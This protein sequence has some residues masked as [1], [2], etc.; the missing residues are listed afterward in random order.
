MPVRHQRKRSRGWRLPP[1][2]VIVTRGTKWGNPFR[3]GHEALP[4][5]GSGDGCRAAGH[6]IRVR[7]A[8]HAVELFR[9]HVRGRED[10]IKADLRGKDLICWCPHGQHCHADVLLEIANE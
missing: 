8:A 6:P 9:A 2:A 5:I 4:I 7:N 3:I 10:E 1:G